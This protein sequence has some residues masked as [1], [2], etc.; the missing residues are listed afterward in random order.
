MSAVFMCDNCGELFSVNTKGWRQSS[1][2]IPASE[3]NDYNQGVKL[4]HMGPCCA[5]GDSVVK[6]NLGSVPELT[7]GPVQD[8]VPTLT[9]EQQAAVDALYDQWKDARDNILRRVK[10]E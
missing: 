5:L 3:S 1:E 2:R 8:A 9:D 6:P 4:R 7:Q 10:G